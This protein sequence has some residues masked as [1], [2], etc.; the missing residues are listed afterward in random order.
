M[1]PN[2]QR[3]S[4]LRE[5]ETPTYRARARADVYFMS[6]PSLP[7]QESWFGDQHELLATWNSILARRAGSGR[8]GRKSLDDFAQEIVLLKPKSLDESNHLLGSR[9]ESAIA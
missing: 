2:A 7:F 4:K 8:T 5:G 6:K 3:A 1:L 9:H